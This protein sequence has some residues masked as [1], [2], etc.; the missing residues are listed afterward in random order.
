MTNKFRRFVWGVLVV[1]LWLAPAGWLNAAPVNI[2]EIAGV[3]VDV[4]SRT[5]AKARKQAIAN[6]EVIAF[7]L[8]LERLTLQADFENLPFLERDE[9]DQFVQD[10]SVD[11]EK[12]SNVRY[13]ADLSFRFKRKEIRQLLTDY[14]LPFAETPSKP[15]LILPVYQAAGA[16][17][18]WDDPNPWRDAWGTSQSNMGLVPKVLPVGD[19][20]D[21]GAIGALQAVEGDRQSVAVIADRYKVSDVIV[22]VASLDLDP[23]TLRNK[24]TVK[25]HRNG[26]DLETVEETVSLLQRQQESLKSLFRRATR[27][28]EIIIE[29]QWKLENL[30]QFDQLG[31]MAVVVPIDDLHHWLRLN[32]KLKEIAVIRRAEIVLMTRDEIRI[33]IHHIG[34]RHQL[35]LALRQADLELIEEDS[36]WLL[37]LSAQAQF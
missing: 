5:A 32:N 6:G 17:G 9:I 35:V 23:V 3:S 28:V 10:F 1:A 26:I 36:E 16:V 12:T 14:D 18:L 30:L 34:T 20:G 25:V 2:Y 37:G 15:V 22:T 11:N 13:L 21:I 27:D 8:L 7:R 19:L 29:D 31:V 33:N 4:T 24:L